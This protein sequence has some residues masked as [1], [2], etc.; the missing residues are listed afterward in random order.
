MMNW[1]W[2]AYV[3]VGL[4]VAGCRQTPQ[5][6]PVLQ[7]QPVSE[8]TRQEL[9][10]VAP[11]ALIGRVVETLPEARLVA[12]GDIDVSN[13]RE[14]DAL[15]FFGGEENPLVNGVVVDVVGNTLH[16]KYDE[17][18][19]QQRAPVTGDLAIKFTK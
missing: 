9:A 8:Q 14:G 12:V 6:P 7:P 15:V 5:E 2:A 10:Q 17:P 18:T 13:F 3:I 1:R 4:A 16:V 11:D 19:S